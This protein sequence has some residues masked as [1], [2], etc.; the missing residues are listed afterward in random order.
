MH[1]CIQ[2]LVGNM[3]FNL[4]L[5]VECWKCVSFCDGSRVERICAIIYVGSYTDGWTIERI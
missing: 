4:S 5:K 2:A 1:S 3:A